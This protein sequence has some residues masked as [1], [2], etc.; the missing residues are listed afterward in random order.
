MQVIK[1]LVEQIDEE[2]S[3]AEKYIKCAYKMKEDYPEL[4]MTYSRLSKEEMN[5][6][7]LLHDQIVKIIEAYK[8]KNEVPE[9]M[10]VLYDYLHN[11]HIEWAERI[12]L[13]QKNFGK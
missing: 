7:N 5:H 4:A 3:D 11:R 10:K 1:N 8:Q 9:G 6:V 13:K 2:L 12:E